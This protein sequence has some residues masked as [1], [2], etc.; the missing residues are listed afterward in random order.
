[1]CPTQ[2]LKMKTKFFFFILPNGIK[3]RISQSAKLA[4]FRFD[5]KF[6]CTRVAVKDALGY[7]KQFD[8]DKVVIAINS[9]IVPPE[10]KRSVMETIESLVTLKNMVTKH[11]YSGVISALNQNEDIQNNLSIPRRFITGE[12]DTAPVV[13]QV[14]I[15]IDKDVKEEA[16]KKYHTSIDAKPDWLS[17]ATI[18]ADVAVSELLTK[19]RKQHEIDNNIQD[20]TPGN[21]LVEEQQQKATNDILEPLKI[22][23]QSMKK[24]TAE[25]VLYRKI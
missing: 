19:D 20:T 7:I 6:V 4:C 15:Q 1:M 9:Y 25:D 8:I 16:T 2:K 24:E 14:S 18:Q 11:Q 12:E 21:T 3:Y 22:I 17:A 13:Q 23:E 10:R 5:E